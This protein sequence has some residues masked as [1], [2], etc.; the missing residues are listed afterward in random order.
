MAAKSEMSD[1]PKKK[2]SKQSNLLKQAKK[3]PQTP[4]PKMTYYNEG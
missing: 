3:K 2:K 1:R 4:I